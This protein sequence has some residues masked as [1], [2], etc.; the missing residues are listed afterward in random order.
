MVQHLVLLEQPER[1]RRGQ[2][3]QRIDRIPEMRQAAAFCFLMPFLRIAVA[4]EEDSLV[5]LDD[6]LQHVS[7]RFL[8]PLERRVRAGS[9]F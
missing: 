6:V 8:Q 3:R 4:V 7:N 1:F 9:L 5:F 2:H